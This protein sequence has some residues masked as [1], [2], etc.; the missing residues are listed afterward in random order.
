VHD[1][2]AIEV[3]LSSGE[4]RYFLTWGRIQD[5]VDPAPVAALVLRKASG[6]AM[7]GEPRS[8]RVLWSLHPAATSPAFWECFFD[9]CQRQIP[10]GPEHPNWREKIAA[11]QEQGKQIWYLGHWFGDERDSQPDEPDATL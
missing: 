3:T 6:F 5:P 7:D 1:I 8:A 2:V 11:E 9:M 10:F 4:R